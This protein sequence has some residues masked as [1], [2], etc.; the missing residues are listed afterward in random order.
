MR[1]LINWIC[2]RNGN[3]SDKTL[4]K[5]NRDWL[6]FK[7]QQAMES[8][9]TLNQLIKLINEYSENFSDEFKE[10]YNNI[11][12]KHKIKCENSSMKYYIENFETM[13]PAILP[14]DKNLIISH[15]NYHIL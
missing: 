7:Q 8:G 2:K 11:K 12:I 1:K 13:N 15:L 9:A 14:E 6:W 3:S 10:E 5:Y 4:N